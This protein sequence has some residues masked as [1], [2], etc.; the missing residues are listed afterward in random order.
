MEFLGGAD[1]G[2]SASA[3]KYCAVQNA[4]RFPTGISAVRNAPSEKT[5]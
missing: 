5:S 4:S 2:N 3:K 1:P